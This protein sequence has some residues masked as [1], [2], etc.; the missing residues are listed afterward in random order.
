MGASGRRAGQ[1]RVG[2]VVNGKW[3]ID[4]RIGSGG[5][6]TVYAATHRKALRTFATA[7]RFRARVKRLYWYQ[8]RGTADTN[9][10][11]TWDTGLVDSSGAA[12][13]AYR[14]ALQQRFKRR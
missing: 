13:P 6:A 7:L 11:V 8:W 3:H 1:G 10:A 12:R 5:M 14:V 9:P 2:T 4:E